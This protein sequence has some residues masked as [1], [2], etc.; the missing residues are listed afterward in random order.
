[1][2]SDVLHLEQLIRTFP[3]FAGIDVSLNSTTTTTGAVQCHQPDQTPPQLALLR[4]NSGERIMSSPST[5]AG[6]R[7]RSAST[8]HNTTIPNTLRPA[9]LLQPSSRDAS[10]EEGDDSAAPVDERPLSRHKKTPSLSIDPNHA[11][12]S[13]RARTR[14]GA[15]AADALHTTSNG[16]SAA[17]NNEDPGEP[18][19][20][21]EASVDIE[22]RSK[23]KSLTANG[24]VDK[25]EF[26]QPLRAGLQD[27]VGYHTNPPPT[28]RAVRVYADGVFDLFHLG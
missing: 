2:G 16:D 10:G 14:S 25:D 1:M 7:K 6:K 20:T 26:L 22:T 8:A 28:G 17:V 19:E 15:T 4:N 11:H 24:D 9:E 27:P 18:S 23:R 13:K 5:T 3:G 12:P 21:T